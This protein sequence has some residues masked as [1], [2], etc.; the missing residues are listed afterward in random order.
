MGK[1]LEHL[2]KNRLE[3]FAENKGILADTQFGFRKGRSTMDSLNIL[4][5]DI[6]LTFSKNEYLLGCFLDISAAYDNVL[7][8]VLRAKM[9]HLSIPAKI[10]HIVTKLFMGRSIKIRNGNSYHPPRTLW[11]GLPQGSVLSPLLYSIY[12]YDLEQSVLSFCNILQ[13]ADDLVLYTSAKSIDKA[14]AS[15]NTAL[16]YLK[17]WLDEHGLTLSPTKS[18]VVTFSRRRIMPAADVRYG[19]VMIPSKESVKFLGVIL[20]H[21]MSGIS[22]H[23]YIIGKCEKNINILRALSGVWWGSHPYCQKL[24]YN[25]I[26]RSHIDYGSFLMEP[27]NKD[28]LGKLDLI[29]AKCLRIILG[30][31]RSSPKNAMQVE[32]V[33][34]PLSLRRQYLADRFLIKASSYYNHLLLP[35]LRS[36]ALELTVYT[37]ASKVDPAR[38]VGAAVWIPRYNI[39]LSFRCPPQASIFT[40]EA[41]AILEASEWFTVGSI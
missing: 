30:A 38:C 8:P 18:C 14:A 41:V 13:Y 23:K 10:V 22:H 27:C 31:M 28:G 26:I 35:R 16:G 19:G 21:K 3:W 9:L 32:G 36:L 15:L 12:T 25:A 37:D 24:L 4:A 1:I 17:D 2:V 6:R 29:Q 39:V 5:T 34:P 11:R 40:G 7:L 20:D 33:E